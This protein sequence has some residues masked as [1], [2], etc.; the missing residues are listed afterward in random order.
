[1]SIPEHTPAFAVGAEDVEMSL[2]RRTCN[3]EDA[4]RTVLA[5][6]NQATVTRDQMEAVHAELSELLALQLARGRHTRMD[7]VISLRTKMEELGKR[8][9]TIAEPDV[10][11]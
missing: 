9:I 6:Y 7:F 2:I 10:V 11:A 4:A 1:M 5:P 8:L 3:A